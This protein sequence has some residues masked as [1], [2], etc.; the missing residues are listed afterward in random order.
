MS[1]GRTAAAATA[2]LLVASIAAGG[3]AVAQDRA[4]LRLYERAAQLLEAGDA[5]AAQRDAEVFVEQFAASELIDE[6]LLLLA[7]AQATNLDNSGA[8]ATADS[9]ISGHPRTAS[10][11]SAMVLVAQLDLDAAQSSA[12]LRQIRESIQ[13]VPLLYGAEDFPRL[14]ARPAAAVIAGEVSLRL[15]ERALAASQLAQ[16]ASTAAREPWR[17]RAHYGLGVALLR[18]GE[19]S[20]AASMLQQAAAEVSA[21]RGLLTL[22]HRHEISNARLPWSSSRVATSWGRT[23]DRPVGVGTSATGEVFVIDEG[24]QMGV[25][26]DDEGTLI[27]EQNPLT[28]AIRPWFAD[29]GRT[30]VVAKLSLL[31]PFARQRTTFSYPD[32]NENKEAENLAAAAQGPFGN[33]LVAYDGGDRVGRFDPD[34]NHLAAPLGAQRVRIVDIVVDA[35]GRFLALDQREKRVFSISSEG[36]VEVA[37]SSAAWR[38]P[39]ALAID[40]LDNLYVLDRDAKQIEIYGRDRTLRHTLGPS[41]PGGQTLDDPRDI[42]VD[43]RGRLLVADRG[44]RGLVVIE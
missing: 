31:A 39:E 43:A 9:L 44:A 22:I 23:L 7:R 4:G 10:A 38:R 12:D 30:Y 42:A 11:A 1:R 36:T 3:T 24:K 18:D 16:A 13:R 25:R 32:G 19:W 15:G 2:L 17:S 21:A 26:T 37:I 27:A 35:N 5:A 41:L 29:T 28:E 8:R 34:G 20:G 14:E 6:G 33:L 40:A